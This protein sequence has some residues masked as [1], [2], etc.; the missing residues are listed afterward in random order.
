MISW[1]HP[2]ATANT[3]P[4]AQ[5]LSRTRTVLQQKGQ[6]FPFTSVCYNEKALVASQM[7]IINDLSWPA[8]QSVSDA[9]SKE[10]F[11][12]CYESLDKDISY[13]KSFGPNPLMSKLNLSDA[14]RH[15]LVDP[16]DW[17]VLGSTWPIVMSDGLTHTVWPLEFPSALSEV[18]QRF[19]IH[20]GTTLELPQ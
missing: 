7:R 18:C 16:C 1:H 5:E 12:C 8:G 4:V 13:L 19:A 11:T 10:L 9:I 3:A 15:I 20:Y 14:F 17:E 2:S 6:A